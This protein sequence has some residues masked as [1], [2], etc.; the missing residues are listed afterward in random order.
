[1]KYNWQIVKMACRVDASMLA[2]RC[3]QLVRFVNNTSN[4]LVENK[5]EKIMI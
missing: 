3:N 1:M 4:S 2:S 5:C